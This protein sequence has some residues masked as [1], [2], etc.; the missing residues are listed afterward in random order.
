MQTADVWIFT[1]L[2]LLVT[3]KE[4]QTFTM[5]DFI[6]KEHRNKITNV[7]QMIREDIG[8]V[9]ADLPRDDL[10]VDTKGKLVN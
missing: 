3:Y 9:T 10:L 2:S 4:G 5:C 1:L 6:S 8:P 7:E